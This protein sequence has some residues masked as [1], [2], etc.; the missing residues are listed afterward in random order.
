MSDGSYSHIVVSENIQDAIRSVSEG[1]WQKFFKSIA[2]AKLMEIITAQKEDLTKV[3][4]SAS[5]VIEMQ[6]IFLGLRS[7]KVVDQE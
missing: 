5:M 4:G 1:E 2:D 3:Q 6:G 7:V